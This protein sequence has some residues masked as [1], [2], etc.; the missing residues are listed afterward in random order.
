LRSARRHRQLTAE[1]TKLTSSWNSVPTSL[2]NS[3]SPPE[4]TTTGSAPK[5]R[6]LS[7]KEIVR[8]LKRYVARELYEII[9]SAI[10]PL[11]RS[12]RP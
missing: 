7:K 8:C 12:P 3:W 4:R 11:T 10:R 1:I 9:T 5:R 6:R 2:V